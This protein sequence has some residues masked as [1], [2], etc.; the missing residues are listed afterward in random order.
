VA[1]REVRAAPIADRRRLA[2]AEAAARLAHPN[3][4][5][6]YDVVAG[7]RGPVLVLE[8][9]TGRP[10]AER[11]AEGPLPPREAVR[12]AVEV[13]RGLAHAH[14]QGVV[15]GDLMAGK[16]FLCEDGQVKV[17]DAGL[18][19]AFGVA[20]GGDERGDVRALGRLIGEAWG[21]R[22]P[23]RLTR[24]LGRMEAEEPAAEQVLGA[25]VALQRAMS[26][27]R[28]VVAALAVAVVA[29]M[30]AGVARARPYLP[31][32]PLL[33]VLADTD[34]R[35][36]DPGLD[37]LS[38]LLRVGFEQ[39]RRLQVVARSRLVRLLGAEGRAVT[40]G[41]PQALSAAV[42]TGARLLLLPAVR[43]VASGF[44]VEV[45]AVAPGRGEVAAARERALGVGTIPDALDRV[46][47][48]VRA[49]LREGPG[50]ATAPVPIARFVPDN[51]E[52]WRLYAEQQ[53]LIS[54]GRREEAQRAGDR[55]LE[56]DPT[57][58]VERAER[59]FVSGGPARRQHVEAALAGLSRLPAK[60]REYVEILVWQDLGGS[61]HEWID[62][63]VRFA[64]RWPEEPNGY[65]SLMA[66]LV[67]AGRKGEAR[68]Y[69]ERTLA[70]AAA[71]PPPVKTFS[72]VVLDRPDDALAAAKRWAETG[73]PEAIYALMAVHLWRGELQE[74]LVAAR[75]LSAALPAVDPL[76]QRISAQNVDTQA[77]AA[78][79]EADA[80]EELEELVRTR[81][82]ERSPRWLLLRGRWRE[83]LALVPADARMARANFL[84]YG[85]GDAEGA[86]RELV[87]RFEAGGGCGPNCVPL[88]LEVG[89]LDRARRLMNVRPDLIEFAGGSLEAFERWRRHDV[90]GALGAMDACGSQLTEYYPAELLAGVGRHR[91]AIDRFRRYR[92]QIGFANNTYAPIT[93]LASYYGRSLLGEA[94]ALERLGERDEALRVIRRLLRLWKEADADY[95]PAREARALEDR[96]VASGVGP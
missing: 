6:L 5:H 86:W 82:G 45:R 15:H 17:L 19:R 32:G 31:E 83:A 93:Q 76:R 68:P 35:T 62:R 33:T 89:A 37:G 88:L 13:A 29:G 34:N 85:F 41:E 28:L 57:F 61:L 16:V 79:L 95:A 43:S 77:W 59:A 87:A 30:A 23:A 20:A 56:A 92:R 12:V 26:P 14:Q 52:A 49:D 84:A 78:Y 25:L 10:L 60:E 55:L 2:E 24:L 65:G 4:V 81:N 74:A 36:G 58:P 54:E 21:G 1:L 96:L 44:D 8:L 80:L 46:V 11:L 70:S 72:F 7:E 47:A 38:E 64:E 42:A 3:L 18:A 40:I 53:R 51:P 75:R 71:I 66:T 9:L 27:R 63:M 69:V 73:D 94:T 48:A 90:E 39:T 91:E 67:V 50:D 22:R